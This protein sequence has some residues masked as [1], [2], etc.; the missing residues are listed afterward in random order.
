M[1][2]RCFVLQIEE[3]ISI[4][5][6][7]QLKDAFVLADSDGSGRLDFEEFKAVFKMELNIS[8]AKVSSTKLNVLHFM[9]FTRNYLA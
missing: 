6:L 1:V 4:D 7:E 5:I 3:R 8:E 2:R 9:P